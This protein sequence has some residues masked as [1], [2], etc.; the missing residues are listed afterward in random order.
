[1]G[2]LAA[3]DLEASG[4]VY[5]GE[6]TL[7]MSPA[8]VTVATASIFE[9][10]ILLDVNEYARYPLHLPAGSRI[11]SVAVDVIANADGERLEIAVKTLDDGGTVTSQG[12]DSTTGTGTV[13]VLI[14][15]TIADKA[16]WVVI[17]NQG[18]G[19][20]GTPETRLV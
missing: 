15:Y 4:D 14:G 10:S 3:V 17:E 20:G 13:S 11:V 7:I 6:R 2:D 8:H 12:D 19:S 9:D 5:H 18:G 16:P 1:T